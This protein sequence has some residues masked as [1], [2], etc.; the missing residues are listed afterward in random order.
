MSSLPFSILLSQNEEVIPLLSIQEHQKFC[1]SLLK[2]Y[3]TY[4]SRISDEKTDKNKYISEQ[5]YFQTQKKQNQKEIMKWFETLTIYQRI[6]ICTIKN[7]WLVNILIQFYLMYKT[8]DSCYLIP[9]KEMKDLFQPQKHFS[10]GD[11]ESPIK[12]FNTSNN[13]HPQN[14][15]QNNSFPNDL[16]FYGN[17]FSTEFP[18]IN[19]SMFNLKE[20][21]KRDKEKKFIDNIKILSLEENILDT[22]TLNKDILSNFKELKDFLKFFSG[23]NYFQDWLLPIKVKDIYNFVLPKWMH[24]NKNLTLFQ[25]IL[26]YIEQQILLNYE[27]FFYSKKIYEYSYSNIIVELYEENKTL[28]SFVKENY[29]F[30]NNNDDINKKEFISLMEIRE[31]M[32]NIKKS[33]IYEKKIN[34][35][36]NIYNYAFKNEFRPDNNN[37]ILSKDF[38]IKIYQD[39]YTESMASGDLGIIRVIEHLTFMQFNDIL[40]ARD[41]LFFALREKI[42]ENQY[43]KIK[44]ELI[45]ENIVSNPNSNKKKNKNKKKKKKNKNKENSSNKKKEDKKEYINENNSNKNE[46]EEEKKKPKNNNNGIYYDNNIISKHNENGNNTKEIKEFISHDKNQKY[47]DNT[48][49]KKDENNVKNIYKINIIEE[50]IKDINYSVENNSLKNNEKN[51]SN[52]LI[53]INNYRINNSEK[54]ITLNNIQKDDE[55]QKEK[56]ENNYITKRN[57]IKKDI[58]LFP[59]IKQKKNKKKKKLKSLSEKKNLE[60]NNKTLIEDKKEMKNNSPTI[61]LNKEIDNNTNYIFNITNINLK[62]EKKNDIFHLQKSPTPLTAQSQ[63][64]S[65]YKTIE[66][67]PKN[68]DLNISKDIST[69]SKIPSIKNTMNIKFESEKNK[70]DN[71]TND[72]INNDINNTNINNVNNF[73]NVNNI[74]N[75]NDNNNDFINNYSS[76]PII[77]SPYSPYTPSEKFFES[78]TK[79]IFNY[80]QITNK[81]ITNLSPIRLK[82][83]TEIENLIKSGLESKYDIKFGH[84]GSHFTDLCIEGSDLDILINYKSKNNNKDNANNND[85]LKDI[86]SILNQNENKF[87]L[88]N[89]ILTASVPVIKLQIDIK[90]EINDIK[91]KTMPYFEDE[92]E[93]TKIN[94]DLTF[95][96]NEQEYQHSHQ[97]VSYINQ[98]LISLPIIKSLLL[99]LKRYFKIM[100]MNKS[101]H[102]GLSSYSLYLLIYTFCKKFPIDISSSGK[103]LYSFLAFFSFFEFDKYGVNAENISIYYLNNNYIYNNYDLEEK[104]IKK[105]INIIDP[106]TKLNV[107]KSSFKVEEIQNTFRSAYNFLIREGCCYDYAV[108]VN[109]T[110]YENDFFNNIKTNFDLD[111]TN[112]FITI[113]KLFALNKK[114]SYLDFFGN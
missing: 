78:L 75:N 87:H 11:G 52:Y 36:N 39:L 93:L 3:L 43:N 102:G 98:S 2:S 42:K 81:N 44:N 37:G 30:H 29:S 49:I 107:A 61:K 88:I 50:D 85:F 40:N 104:N 34:N 38:D 97:I 96:Q 94:I 71:I 8:Y 113:K 64:F 70:I 105:E 4:K 26:G 14:Y 6:K 57:N 65:F 59:T 83:L 67:P 79:E 17:F 77:S 13:P 106:L 76:I 111:K 12:G 35:L 31:I 19:C 48:N 5:D 47:I 72:N 68:A 66:A 16:N 92:D 82:Y 63:S 24:N 22:I 84:Y 20:S 23:D 41:N 62:I 60:Q 69:N 25:L 7:K 28:V 95:T 101:F 21:E 46:N 45:S 114:H 55:D 109:K 53:N 15:K 10:H 74:N 73:N 80:I 112:D 86:L 1:K 18:G 58:F 33:Q 90:N 110:G 27:Y 89:P 100:K 56:Y 54:E 91:L 51:I 32:K 103:A 99:I 9:I 108:L